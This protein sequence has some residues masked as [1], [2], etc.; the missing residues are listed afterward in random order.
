MSREYFIGTS[1]SLLG[2]DFDRHQ[3]NLL[4]VPMFVNAP[5]IS[6]WHGSGEQG[7]RSEEVSE[8]EHPKELSCDSQG[9]EVAL[10]RAVALNSPPPGEEKAE[11]C[12]CDE[13]I[14]EKIGRVHGDEF[15]ATGSR[16]I[17]E[18]IGKRIIRLTMES[19]GD[20]SIIRDSLHGCHERG[21]EEGKG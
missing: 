17:H 20:S 5:G 3:R 18:Q 13:G 11:D 21:E 10:L 8:S 14:E 7:K 15:G 19:G 9:S 6:W 16:P 2:H 12:E 1:V 4:P